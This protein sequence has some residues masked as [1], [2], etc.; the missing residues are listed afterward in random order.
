MTDQDGA[1]A[2]LKKLRIEMLE[3]IL[4]ELGARATDGRAPTVESHLRDAVDRHVEA[5]LAKRLQ[6]VQLSEADLIA[7]RTMELFTRMAFDRV[8]HGEAEDNREDRRKTS[9]AKRIPGLTHRWG[10]TFAKLINNAILISLIALLVASTVLLKL[11]LDTDA[12]RERRFN[13][14]KSAREVVQRA[15]Q[16]Q[17]DLAGGADVVRDTQQWKTRCAESNTNAATDPLCVAER[18]LSNWESLPLCD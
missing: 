13:D 12:E 16:R 7:Q 1:D 14:A 15:C 5:A 17:Q 8:D 6:Q 2:V 18:R 11:Y 10:R 4:D 9:I 3:F